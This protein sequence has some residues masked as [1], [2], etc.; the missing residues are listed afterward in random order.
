M[1]NLAASFLT[2]MALLA[3][4]GAFAQR[5]FDSADAA[6]NAIVDKI[7]ADEQQKIMEIL[8][9]QY[10][11]RLVTS[12][13]DA[14]QP[15]RERIAAAAREK[16]DSVPISD[17]RVE[18]LLGSD[19]WPFPFHTVHGDDGSWSFDTEQGI[20]ALIDRRVGRN[21]LSAIAI[22]NAYV[23]AQIEYAREDR[24]NDGVLEYARRLASSDGQRD[25][26]YWESERGEPESP[27]GPLVNGAEAYLDTVGKGD[28]IRGYYFRVLDGQGEHAPGGAHSYVIN[29]H[30]IAGFALVAYPAEYGN[31]GVMTFIVNNRGVIHQKVIED[32]EGMD[33]YDPDDSWVEVKEDAK[34]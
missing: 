11:D 1:V 31:T 22:V 26:L 32:L 14:E 4:T 28:P 29:D 15:G 8:G 10:T 3:P 9:S 30:M 23:D 27:F 17:G 5:R 7:E 25:G 18:W 16:L 24:D 20:E 34:Q 2:L 6:M 21:E 13:W 19:E 33:A 12:D